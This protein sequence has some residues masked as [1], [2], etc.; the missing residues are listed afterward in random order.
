MRSGMGFVYCNLGTLGKGNR[1]FAVTESYSA[2]SRNIPCDKVHRVSSYAAVPPHP[3][4]LL[5]TTA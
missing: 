3:P 5:L 2:I 4:G 1:L